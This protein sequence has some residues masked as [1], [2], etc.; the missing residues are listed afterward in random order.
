MPEA[1]AAVIDEVCQPLASELGYAFD[2]DVLPGHPLVLTPTPV[3][4][5]SVPVAVPV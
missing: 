4:D 3:A 2:G 1:D 5:A